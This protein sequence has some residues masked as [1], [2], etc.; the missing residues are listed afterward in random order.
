M[1]RVVKRLLLDIQ[2]LA[3]EIAARAAEIEAVRDIPNDLVEALRSIGIYRMFVPQRHGGLELD[4]PDG[5]KVLRALA[6]IE[7]SVGW[8]AMI[9]SVTQ[10]F[11]PLMQR[12]IYDEVYR[13]G[14]DVIMAGSN[15]PGGTAEAAQG[16]WRVSG[17][18]P[19]A[20]GCRHAVFIGGACV[21]TKAG[22]PLPGPIAGVPL[23]RIF[24]L[25]A[26][27]W[28][29]EDSWYAAG[30]KGTGSSH[31]AIK[32]A[33]VPA[34]NF[35]DLKDGVPCVPGPLYQ[36]PMSVIPLLHGPFSVGVAEGAL[37]DL[38]ALAGTGRRQFLATT[39]MRDAEFFQYEMGRLEAELRATEAFLEAEGARHWQ[40]ALERR[41]RDEALFIRALQNSAWLSQS[42]TRIVD[43]CFALG[44]SSVIYD[45][46]PLQRRLRDLHVA[47]QHFTAQQRNYVN[48]GKLLLNPPSRTETKVT[49]PAKETV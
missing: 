6:R 13:N 45:T 38:L 16:G 27:H 39:S 46:S 22:Q 47:G 19:L 12:D 28:Q 43:Q 11:A 18:W 33:F 15:Q 29:T 48:A 40:H 32:D 42:C 2:D 14:P 7:A 20:S 41:L 8:T 10:I 21:M 25:P 17:R 44:G 36:A 49:A 35:F 26:H 37:D 9:S 34:E 30:L 1:G 4:L 3:P 24:F 5:F 31:V 23:M